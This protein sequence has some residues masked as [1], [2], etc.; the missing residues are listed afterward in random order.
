MI[1]RFL[2][3]A[4]LLAHG[5]SAFLLGPRGTGK[6]MLSQAFL[7]RKAREGSTV[8]H[9]DLLSLKEQA[10]YVQ[11]PGL[12]RS[13]I[14]HA[15]QTSSSQIVV[16][17]DEVQKVPSLLDEV[18]YFLESER[19]RCQFLLTGSSAR[20]LKRGGA[21]LLAGRALS[22]ALHPL[23]LL[24]LPLVL[25]RVLQFG[26]LPRY[27][28]EQHEA[29]LLLDAYV[30]TYLKEEIQA[31]RLVRK[32]EPFHRFL[33]LAAQMNGRLLNHTTIA[34]ELRLS[35][36]AVRDYYS[37]L[38]DTLL[39]FSLPAWSR[40]VRKQLTAA[41]RFYF[42]D[43]GV[44]NA[45]KGEHILKPN[46]STRRYGELFESFIIAE[47][48]RQNSYLSARR[49]FFHWRVSSGVD[50]VDLVIDMGL[51]IPPIAIEI[52]SAESVDSSDL[53]SLTS[54]K[55]EF[56]DAELYCVCRTSH[57]YTE[58]DVEILPWETGVTTILNKA[59][60]LQAQNN[61]L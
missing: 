51:H 59:L 20:K 13:D 23:C 19:T 15:L 16:L 47:F 24:D 54:F 40:S 11:D 32:L 21:N 26:S 52:K 44:L 25:D 31:E 29:P 33:Q 1:S 30:E 5:H 39:G 27:Y 18:H 58:G 43:T 61:K 4:S 57:A 46:P 60:E 48:F 55:R 56:P 49:S 2:D 14:N 50:E 9:I 7:K 36:Q 17:I 37:I 6:T 8:I 3:L 35:D 53:R 22:L 28:L 12:F 41:P 45:M 42:F 38:S 10:R 34:K